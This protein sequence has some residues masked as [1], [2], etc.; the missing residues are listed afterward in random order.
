MK[1][2]KL[3]V[4]LFDPPGRFPRGVFP[5]AVGQYRLPHPFNVGDIPLPFSIL[6]VRRSIQLD[7]AERH[8]VV[9]S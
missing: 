8:A 2:A 3:V 1:I 4:M 5:A 9:E 7:A 6:R